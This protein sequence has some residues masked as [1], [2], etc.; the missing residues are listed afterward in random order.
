MLQTRFRRYPFHGNLIY[1]QNPFSLLESHFP[2][3][4][5][6]RT[7]QNLTGARPL[8]RFPLLGMSDALFLDTSCLKIL[9]C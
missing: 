7:S 1:D 8:T 4:P 2:I 5:D 3:L 9:F 6:H